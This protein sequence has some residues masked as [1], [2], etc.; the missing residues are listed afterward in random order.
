[1]STTTQLHA[2]SPSTFDAM[3]EAFNSVWNDAVCKRDGR[4]SAVRG[5]ENPA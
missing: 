2:A 4:Q 3:E 5:I 1:M